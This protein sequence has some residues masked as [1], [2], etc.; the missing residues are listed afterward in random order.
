MDKSP[1]EEKSLKGL[2]AERQ[3]V[4][5]CIK[6]GLMSQNPKKINFFSAE[7]LQVSN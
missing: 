5:T 6:L 3:I 7:Y 4:L 2:C 1:C